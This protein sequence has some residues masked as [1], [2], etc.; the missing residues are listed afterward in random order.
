[1]L[2]RFVVDIPTAYF[3]LKNEAIKPT[4]YIFKSNGILKQPVCS[5]ENTIAIRIPDD[6]FCQAILHQFNAPILSTSANLSG[7]LAPQNFSFIH[8]NIK[9]NVDYVVQYRQDDDTEKSASAII[10]LSNDEIKIIRN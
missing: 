4:T 10:D 5:I 3:K 6:A 1:M 7:D 8:S 2:K 9:Q